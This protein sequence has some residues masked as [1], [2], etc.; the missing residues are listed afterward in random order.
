LL[1]GPQPPS[2]GGS[3]ATVQ[4]ILKE[5]TRYH[6]VQTILVNTSPPLDYSKKRM[7]G[8]SLEKLRRAVSIVRGYV[9]GVRHSD[10]VLVLANNL[11]ACALVPLLFLLARLFH[12][13]FFLKPVGGDLGLYIEASRKPFRTYLL[14]VLRSL[15]GVLAQ[16]R[17][18]QIALGQFG[19]TNVYYVPGCRPLPQIAGSRR[20]RSEDLRL[21]F[22]SHITREKGSFI[23]LEALR[24]LEQERDTAVSCDFYG[25]IFE[26]DREEF[27]RQLE[28]TASAGYR[29]LVEMETASRLIA[30]YD[31]LVLPTYFVSE[32][33][34]GAI[35]EAMMAAVPVISTRHRSIPDLITHGENGLLVPV[36]DSH[37]LAEAIMQIAVDHT[38]RERMGEAN[39]RRGQEFRTD[40]VVP[41]MLGIMFPSG[42][43]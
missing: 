24:L 7:H 9:Q 10:A 16:T 13:P 18:L 26:E 40:V 5:L 21:I 37:A 22:L 14:C 2:V 17:D 23:L 29:G 6:S 1:V 31:A 4:A 25:P 36:R 33:H 43:E 3:S 8:P 39:F 38:F 20:N 32:G 41:L 11:F 19:C 15:D 42:I 35:I 27:I 30:T 34:P 28:A 12:T